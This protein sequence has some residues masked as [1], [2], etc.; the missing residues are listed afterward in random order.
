MDRFSILPYSAVILIITCLFIGFIVIDDDSD[1]DAASITG[2]FDIYNSSGYSFTVGDR[3]NISP[4]ESYDGRALSVTSGFGLYVSNGSL[5]G[6]LTKAGTFT[7]KISSDD[8]SYTVTW[9][10]K[11]ATTSVTSISITGS[12]SVTKGSSITLTATTSPTAA[13]DRTVTWS[14]TSGGS[15]A[16]ISSTSDTTTGGK[17]VIK[18]VSAGSVTVRATAA[19][20]SGVYATK[21]ITVSNPSYSYYLYYDANGGSGA[22]ST[23]SKTSSSTSSNF[24]FTISSTVPTRSGYT[25]LG[26]ST[27]ST[28][29]TA[30]YQPGGSVYVDYNDLTLY[31]VWK[32]ITYTCNLNFNANGGSGAPSGLSYTGTS[33]SNHSF[34]IPSMVP[35]RTGY[36]FLGWSTSSSAATASYH[37]GGTIS[38][39][40]ASTVTLYAVWEE[41]E[42]VLSWTT[43]PVLSCVI[44]PVIVYSDDGSFT[45]ME[46]SA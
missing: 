19:D 43:V 44:L 40:Y 31:A 16:T 7:V 35:T 22:P 28:A 33:T 41:N 10:S 42:P 36:T 46:G 1:V 34:I 18:G 17:C 9:T 25:F 13:T 15:Y 32:Q 24:L 30:S 4:A 21:T 6:T 37:S 26:W 27:S 11:A 14:I 2:N 20:G 12:T 3:F 8:G 45:I 39:G 23:Q 5:L 38:V 29:T